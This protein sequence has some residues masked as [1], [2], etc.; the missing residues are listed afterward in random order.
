MF[1][2][3]FCRHNQREFRQVTQSKHEPSVEFVTNRH[4]KIQN[5]AMQPGFTFGSRVKQVNVCFTQ[6]KRGVF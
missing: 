2:A 6:L 5:S 3:A 1:T 4:H